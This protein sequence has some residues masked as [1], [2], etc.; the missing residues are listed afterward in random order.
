MIN[1]GPYTV[2]DI[3]LLRAAIFESVETEGAKWT[4]ANNVLKDILV[5]YYSDPPGLNFTPK[6]LEVMARL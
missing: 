4:K 5:G 6:D 1:E 3:E 2:A